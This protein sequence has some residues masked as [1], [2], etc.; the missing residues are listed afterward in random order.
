MTLWILGLGAL[1][2]VIAVVTLWLDPR[3]PRP[4]RAKQGRGKDVYISGYRVKITP[5]QEFKIV[6][7]GQRGCICEHCSWYVND[8]PPALRHLCQASWY[9]RGDF[10]KVMVLEGFLLRRVVG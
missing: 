7:H 1:A 3:A 9:P 2:W 6:V 4:P 8:P 10:F 5:L